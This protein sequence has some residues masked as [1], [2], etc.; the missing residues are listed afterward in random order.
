MFQWK[1]REKIYQPNTMP[2]E[3]GYVWGTAVSDGSIYN[4]IN[5]EYMKLGVKDYDFAKLFSTNV[6]HITKVTYKILGPYNGYYIVLVTC[7]PLVDRLTAYLTISSYQWEVP[8][9]AFHNMDLARGF[10][11]AY[12]DGDGSPS[13]DC[14]NNLRISWNSVN[15]TGISQ[16]CDLLN[17]F[18]IHSTLNPLYTMN[19]YGL[20]V[21]R[22]DDIIRYRDIIGITMP[23][24][25]DRLNYLINHNKKQPGQECIRRECKWQ[26]R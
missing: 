25:R 3:W 24:K 21:S 12:L 6:G 23:R 9:E 2:Y 4:R 15:Q 16:V 17:K 14:H 11:N 26:M 1:N 10:L 19:G 18:G 20:T 22:W 13:K 5:K 8:A 7:P